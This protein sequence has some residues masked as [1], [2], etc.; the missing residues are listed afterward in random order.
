M[1]VA[2]TYAAFKHAFVH[3][4]KEKTRNADQLIADERHA[5]I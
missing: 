2:H 4:C 3:G 5:K 1:I